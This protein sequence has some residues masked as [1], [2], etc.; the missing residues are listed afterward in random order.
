MADNLTHGLAAAL[1]AQAGFQQRYG[2][3]ATLALVVG[4]ELPDLDALYR[5]AGPVA[6]FVHHRGFT[7]SILGGLGLA[8]LGAALLWSL[9]R[10]QPYWRHVWLVYMGVLLHIWMDY[11][12][13]YG[14]QIL[15]PFDAG[16]YT[17]DTVF[18]VDYT[19]S[20]IMII[21]L[22]LVRMVRQ[23]R[24]RRYL[25]VAP[26]WLLLGATFWLSA[27]TLSEAAVGLPNWSHGGPYLVLGATLML[28]APALLR[29]RASAYF[30][31]AWLQGSVWLL[32]AVGLW[33]S[34]P[35]VVPL[36]LVP[37]A[38]QSAGLHVMVC[39][40]LVFLAAWV[41]RSWSAPQAVYFGR[42]GVL[43]LAAYV[44][45]CALSNAAVQR[46]MAHALGAQMGTVRR[47]SALPLPGGGALH[48]RVIAE[49]D[50]AYLVS[51]VSL[52][53]GTVTLP[54]SIAKG[55]DSALIQAL[56][57]YRLVQIF[58]D[59]ARFPVITIQTLGPDTLVHFA[60]LRFSG[61]GRG[62]SRFNLTVQLDQTGSVRAIEFLNRTF[63][64]H[65][66]E[67]ADP[68]SGR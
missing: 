21:G 32:L 54:Q 62:R 50:Q 36:P 25:A 4:S 22:V 8:M 24:Q 57:R 11:L 13:S 17:S 23:Q 52:L 55:P 14:T 38:R 59:F 6:D 27:T 39:S 26:V 51:R 2:A 44:A 28:G 68:S 65:H 58:W 31:P 34:T 66:P 41:S 53:P 37:M 33:L 29:P 30:E 60:D 19:Y 64:P 15:L 20:A 12:T 56:K 43:L 40:L 3:V 48:W 16:R 49:T 9:W 45:L 63:P 67:F 42:L 61:D 1:L 35:Y 47:L 18:I 7:H 46:Q 5:F 10:T